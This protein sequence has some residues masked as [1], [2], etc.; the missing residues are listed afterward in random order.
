M[1][2][3]GRAGNMSGLWS[4]RVTLQ[5]RTVYSEQLD[6]VLFLQARFHYS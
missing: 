3:K 5:Y 6:E 2:A 1:L 4:R